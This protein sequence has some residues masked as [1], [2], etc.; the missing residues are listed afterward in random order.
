MTE[1]FL[2][3]RQVFRVFGKDKEAFLQSLLT[4]DVSVRPCYGALLSSNG[5]FLHD[6]F[7]SEENDHWVMDVLKEH[8]NEIIKK[9]NLYKLKSDVFFEED[10]RQVW[11]SPNEL[12]HNLCFKDSRH[13]NMGYRI[14]QN[15]SQDLSAALSDYI[16]H[17]IKLGIPESP[18][19]LIYDKS[20]ILECN[21]VEM[22]A[23]SFKKGC[24][25]GQELIARTYHLGQIRKRLTP[26]NLEE[27]K[28]QHSDLY[29]SVG[30]Q[31]ALAMLPC[32]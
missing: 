1:V 7:I 22:D 5:R 21:F 12:L 20:I 14:Y 4:C 10:T 3:N 28:G 31:Y 30:K 29:R 27:D 18:A 19:D 25:V 32:V 8:A 15:K 17:R 6:F 13:Q 11:W 23:V 16:D 2:A 9:L 26:I 24:Y